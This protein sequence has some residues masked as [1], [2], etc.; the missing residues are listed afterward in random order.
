MK[1]S[2]KSKTNININYYLE[3]L[4]VFD[5]QKTISFY[6]PNETSFLRKFKFL[7]SE[8]STGKYLDDAF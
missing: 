5:N 6:L 3:L 8:K 4:F 1:K 2:I 7:L